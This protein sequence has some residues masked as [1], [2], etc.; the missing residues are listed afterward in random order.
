MY[1][2]GDFRPVFSL[3]FPVKL[4]IKGENAACFGA[5]LSQDFVQGRTKYLAVS[6]GRIPDF[7]NKTRSSVKFSVAALSQTSPCYFPIV[8]HVFLLYGALRWI[9]RWIAP[10]QSCRR[11]FWPYRH[12][13]S[14]Q[15]LSR[16]HN[17]QRNDSHWSLADESVGQP[18]A[19]R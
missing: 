6:A 19:Q 3:G 18:L 5:R 8:W 4:H 16:N 11:N 1:N 2:G 12:D 17:R 15:K 13:R 7:H 10:D 14:V 9:L